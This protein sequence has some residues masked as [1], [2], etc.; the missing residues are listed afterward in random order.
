[1]DNIQE[2]KLFQNKY[3]ISSIRLKDYDYSQE[4][5]YF[6]TICTRGTEPWFGNVHNG[7]MQLNECG[8]LAKKYWEEIPKHYKYVELDEYII[9]SDHVHGIMIINNKLNMTDGQET[10][11]GASVHTN[12]KSQF[13]SLKSNSVSS[14]INHY[15][16][17]VKKWCNMNGYN[18]FVWKD[19][20]HDRIIRNEKELH[21]IREYI[22]NNPIDYIINP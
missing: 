18:D 14:I 22:V 16:G 9:M 19:R 5:M 11:R 13:G 10:R 2:R 12:I 3:R 21:E 8:E 7:G 6:I 17:A 1:M 15:K 20:F 4:G